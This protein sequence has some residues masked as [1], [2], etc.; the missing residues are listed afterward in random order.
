M[1]NLLTIPNMV[2]KSLA[3]IAAGLALL[4]LGGCESTTRIEAR[5]QS[6][7]LPSLRASFNFGKGAEA[8]S[9]PRDGHAVE[10]EAFRGKASD[11]Q[12]L[13]ANQSPIVLD[14]KTFTPPVQLQHEFRFTYGD[15]SWRWRK[16]FGGGTVGLDV[17]AGMGVAGLDLRTRDGGQ[18][19]ARDYSTRGAQ[20]GVGLVWRL[21]PGTSLQVRV[22]EF[23]SLNEGVDRISRAEVSF[24]QALGPYV[25]G[26]LG[27][28]GWEVRGGSLTNDSDFRLRF[29]GPTLGLQFDF[30]N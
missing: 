12:S 16:F 15:V 10:L 1:P 19:A 20:G 25:S 26:R 17:T 27:W 23:A 7:V 6:V 29:S 21:Q 14:G 22:T 5:D 3:G 9:N 11:T 8:P 28:A 30:G 2:K 24:A 4:G 13:Q 18:Q